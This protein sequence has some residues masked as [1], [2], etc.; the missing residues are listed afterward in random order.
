MPELRQFFHMAFHAPLV[1]IQQHHAGIEHDVV[2]A[3][4]FS[5]FLE[6][7][8][9]ANPGEGLSLQIHIPEFFDVIQNNHITVEIDDAGQIRQEIR[10]LQ[11][12]VHRFGDAPAG[13][14]CC[15]VYGDFL[16]FHLRGG[17]A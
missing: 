13:M 12:V 4:A 1:Q 5:L 16:D 6:A 9:V 15:R 17:I 8:P 14:E 2:R 7:G 3:V 11:T 10:I